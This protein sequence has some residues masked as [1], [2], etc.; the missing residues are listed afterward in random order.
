[1]IKGMLF[2]WVR[3]RGGKGEELERI[4]GKVRVGRLMP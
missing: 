4:E 2:I 1:M 3:M